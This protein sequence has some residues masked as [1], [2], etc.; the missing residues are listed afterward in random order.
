MQS[1][2]YDP[3][4]GRFINA[5]GYIGANG[6]IPGYNLFAYCSNNPVMRSDPTGA[7]WLWDT[8]KDIGETIG[9]WFSDTFGAAVYESNSYADTTDIVV[10]RIE[11]GVVTSGVIAGDNTQPVTFYAQAASS[12][13]KVWEYQV[14]VS[15]N[16]GD[17]GFNV[18]VGFG[19]MSV[20][21]TV[22]HTSC[23]VNSGIYE[24]GCTVRQEVDF[25]NRTAGTYTGLYIRPWTLALAVVAPYS[26]AWQ[27]IVETIPILVR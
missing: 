18:G 13:W 5:D 21:V 9:G 15:I 26:M 24:L 19:E 23:E 3:I 16:F 8:L 20:N 22:D 17:G 1:R 7:W 2:Y 10:G 12:W 4:V 14:G 11:E 27:P 25:K 6:D